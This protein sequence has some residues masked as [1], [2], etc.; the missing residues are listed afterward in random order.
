VLVADQDPRPDASGVRLDLGLSTATDPLDIRSH[1][2]TIAIAITDHRYQQRPAIRP[3]ASDRSCRPRPVVRALVPVEV[4][5][6]PAHRDTNTDGRGVGAGGG[7]EGRVGGDGTCYVS[8]RGNK[9]EAQDVGLPRSITTR[10]GA[11]LDEAGAG[12]DEERRKREASQ[13]IEGGT[14]LKEREQS[15]YSDCGTR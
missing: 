10:R 15:R 1:T 3:P 9:K 4:V 8:G 2:I 11:C 7:G 13:G 6:P 12:K 5:D 14:K